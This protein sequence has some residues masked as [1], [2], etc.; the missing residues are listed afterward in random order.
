MILQAK[1]FLKQ[2]FILSKNCPFC[3]MKY[4]TTEIIC[5][6]CSDTIKM[7]NQQE[8]CRIC[9]KFIAIELNRNSNPINSIPKKNSPNDNYRLCGQCQREKPPYQ[10]AR[11]IAL[12]Q[13]LFKENIYKLKYHGYRSLA[14]VLA[15]MM[16]EKIINSSEYHSFDGIIPIPLTREK[17]MK[18][19]YNHTELLADEIGKLLNIPVYQDAIIRITNLSSQSKL[20]RNER[21]LNIKDAFQAN[22]GYNFFNK[23]FLLVD[24]IVTTGATITE[25]SKLLK[26]NGAKE[27]LVISL[28]TGRTTVK[29]GGNKNECT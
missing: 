12:Y 14:Q 18:R 24:D 21:A 6:K 28:V 8:F 2:L 13:G 11:G 26:I 23:K 3:G 17:L 5:Q 29:I 25:C 22:I 16:V 7:Y 27:I 10:A 15:R 9:G 4:H 20:N 1:E 19:R